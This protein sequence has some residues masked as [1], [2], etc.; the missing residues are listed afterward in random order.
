MFENDNIDNFNSF[1]IINND[2]SFNQNKT[3]DSNNSIF[4]YQKTLTVEN[5]INFDNNKDKK[6]AE[7]G[8]W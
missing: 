3:R 5:K 1:E 6:K 2:L 4:N 7:T 8:I